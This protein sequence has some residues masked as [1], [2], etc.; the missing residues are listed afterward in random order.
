[1][2]WLWFYNLKLEWDDFIFDEDYQ[3]WVNFFQDLS[4]MEKI[5][6]N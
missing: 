3:N 5:K 2:R 6:V 4:K 1:M